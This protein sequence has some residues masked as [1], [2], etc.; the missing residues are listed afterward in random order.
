MRFEI[1]L[2]RPSHI[3]ARGA[4]SADPE[5]WRDGLSAPAHF[6]RHRN[7]ERDGVRKRGL[8][9]AGGRSIDRIVVQPYPSVR[10]AWADMLRGRRRHAVRGRRR[11]ARFAQR[12]SNDASCSPSTRHYQY[13]ARSSTL[14]PARYR[15]ASVRRALNA[16]IDRDALVRDAFEGPRVAVV[17][18]RLAQ[19][20]G[21]RADLPRSPVDPGAARPRRTS[22][23]SPVAV[24]A[25]CD[26]TR[27]TALVVQ[28]QLRG[29]RRRD[30]GPRRIAIDQIVQA[31]ASGDFD[32]VLADFVS[33][34]SLFRPYQ[35]WH[36][37][38]PLNWGDYRQRR[39]STR[40]STGS[41]TR[42]TTTSTAR[43]SPAFS[44]RSSTIR[45][46]SFSPGANARAPSATRFDVAA[47]PGRDILT[48]LRLWRPVER[49]AVRQAETEY[50]A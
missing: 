37:E 22:R 19:P 29:R 39:S 13:I 43:P 4:R 31:I 44:A 26:R 15:D 38:G 11:C 42:R 32:A 30:G 1:R 40:R 33:G 27:A 20:L 25:S 34:P 3:P 47:E 41:V 35:F 46:R 14:K 7:A 12:A 23:S 50:G 16:A 45:R 6:V 8:L 2:R 21:F 36:S 28:R 10:S 17:R 5:A 9:P 24:H 18:P 48:T 49:P